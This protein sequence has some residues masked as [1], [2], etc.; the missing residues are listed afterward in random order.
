MYNQEEIERFVK[1]VE[2]NKGIGDKEKLADIIQKEFHLEKKRS[3]YT[4]EFFS[5][6]FSEFKEEN[7]KNGRISN[8]VLG[9]STLLKYD[10]KPFFVCAIS[11]H[12]NYLWITNTTF[13]YKITHSSQKLTINKIRGSFLGSDIIMQYEGI[14]NRPENFE[15]L[16]AIHEIMPV[17]DNIERLVE[18]TSQI[19]GGGSQL[20]ITPEIREK[21]LK[22]ITRTKEFLKSKEYEDLM[23]DLSGRVKKVQEV[24]FDAAQKKNVNKRGRVIEFLITGEDLKRKEQIKKALEDDKPLPDIT[25]E[26]NLGDYSKVYPNYYVETDIKTKLL[27]RKGNPK[28]YNVDKLLEFLATEKAVYMIFILGIKEDGTMTM[29]LCSILDKYCIENTDIITQ[30]CGRKSRGV[31]QFR[32]KGLI[33]ML[34]GNKRTQ[35][36]EKIAREFL[37]KLMEIPP[38]K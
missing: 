12:T 7:G 5:V 26:D 33:Q 36:D 10:D 6:R 1:L 13:L 32:E 22:S 21:I 37:E 19:E 23:Q 35:I 18:N 15:K 24:I 25:T 8:T 4:N 16:F 11:L 29:K 20:D 28:A 17:E 30:W 34:E 31:A 38:K 14:E 27:F 9:L 3:V 2:A